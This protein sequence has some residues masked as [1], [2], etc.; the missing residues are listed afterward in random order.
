M[1]LVF[2]SLAVK[3]SKKRGD[4]YEEVVRYLRVK[5]RRVSSRRVRH[6]G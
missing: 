5:K 6:G 1:S 3:I 4:R 2:K